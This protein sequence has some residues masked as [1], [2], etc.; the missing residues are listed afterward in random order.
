MKFATVIIKDII[1]M[2]KGTMTIR[3]IIPDDG[4]IITL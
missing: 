4:E 1:T 3:L 2:E